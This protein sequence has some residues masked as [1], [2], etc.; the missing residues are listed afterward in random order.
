LVVWRWRW[1]EAVLALAAP[2][3]A[4]C[5]GLSFG[6]PPKH[7]TLETYSSQFDRP[8]VDAHFGTG[9]HGTFWGESLAEDGL[10]WR[11]AYSSGAWLDPR[12]D[13]LARRRRIRSEEKEILMGYR[14]SRP[15]LAITGWAGAVERYETPL[16]AR[17]RLA[18]VGLLDAVLSADTGAY[19]SARLRVAGA[20]PLANLDFSSG[21]PLF[22][23]FV[24]IGPE[25]G[26]AFS[27]NLPPETRFGGVVTFPEIR[28]PEH[29]ILLGQL[30]VQA[31]WSNAAFGRRGF[32]TGAYVARRW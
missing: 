19:V 29:R 7:H 8:G 12:P 11:I 9:A 23:G 21:V 5:A 22:D 27:R 2:L 6:E 1:R 18:G 30:T 15:G 26:I 20:G 25:A 28:V 13:A 3:H 31:G 10:R 24:K 4:G 14:W 16:A 32:Y 17:P